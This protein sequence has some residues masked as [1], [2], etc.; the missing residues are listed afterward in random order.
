MRNCIYSQK[1]YLYALFVAVLFSC[2]R[3]EQKVERKEAIRYALNQRDYESAIV[4]LEEL[5]SNSPKD[6]QSR[7][8]L[9]SAYS[10]SI[11]INAIDCFEVLRPKLF[12]RPIGGNKGNAHPVSIGNLYHSTIQFTDQSVESKKQEAIRALEKQ[13]L[14]FAR[15]LGDVFEAAFK[16]PHVPADQRE[17][18]N[19]SLTLLSEVPQGSEHYMTAQ[20]YLGILAFVQ[21]MNYFRDGIPERLSAEVRETMPWY[22]AIYCQLD[23]G[24]L[25]PNLSKAIEF[26]TLSLDGVYRAKRTSQSSVFKNLEFASL[27]L[28][29]ANELYLVNQDIFELSEWLFRATKYEFCEF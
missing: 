18:I 3:T 12:D 8:L 5:L 24:L 4:L 10:G 19:K 6:D 21:F 27:S 9:A 25:L 29:N 14:M 16:I 13:L 1:R 11:G 22:L 2:Y 20:L 15:Q 26:L 23:L 7:I 17:L 28:K